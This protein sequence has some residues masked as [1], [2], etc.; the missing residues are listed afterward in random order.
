VLNP[1]KNSILS[2]ILAISFMSPAFAQTTDETSDVMEEVVVMATKREQT[3]QEVPIAVSVV[4]A[5]VLEQAHITDMIQLQSLVPSLKVTQLQTTGN[6]NFIIR[7]FGN[8][9]NNPGIE[10]SVG[11]FIDGVYRSRSASAIADLP[12]LERIEVLRGPQSTLFGKNASAGVINIVTAAPNMNELEGYGEFTYGNYN[13]VILKGALSGPISD[14]FGFSLAVNGNSRDGYFDNLETGSEINERSRWGV[15]GQL[16]WLPSDNTTLRLIADYDESDEKC[17]GVA[18]LVAGPTTGAILLVG[19]NIVPNDAFAREQYFDF[20][21]TNKIENQGVSLQ[22]DF[23][24]S[25]DMVLTSITAYREMSRLDNAD[26]DFTSAELISINS[27]DTDIETFTQEFRLSQSTDSLDWML[28]AYYFD[29]DLTHDNDIRY[30]S[31]FRPYADILSSGNVTLLEQTMIGLGLLPPSVRFFDT[32]QGAFDRAGQDD[33][34][35]SLFG[36][37]DWHVTDR[38]TLTAGANYTKVKKDAFI[39]QTNTDIFSALDMVEVGFGAGFFQ[40]TGLPPSLENIIANPGAA[41]IAN[42]LSTVPCSAETGPA[43]NPLLGLQPLQFLPPF[44]DFPNSVESGTSDDSK[45]TWTARAAFQANDNINLY[46][47]AGTGFKA[48]SWNLSRDSRPFLRD[49]PALEAAGLTVNNLTPGT[50][51]AGP[52]EALVYELGFKGSWQTTMLNM[53]LFSQE[54]DGFQS[55]IFTG[56]GFVLANAGKQSTTGLE[57]DSLWLPTESLKFNFSGTWLDPEYDSFVQGEGV[58]GPEDLSGTTPSG[59]PE[60]SM[61]LAGTYYFDFGSTSGFV[62]GEYIYE[63]DVQVVENVSKEI[64]SR[65][66]SMFNA[67]IGLAWSNGLE[68][69]LWGRNLNNDDFLLSAFPGVAQPGTFSGYPNQPRTY[70]VTFRARF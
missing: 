20:D 58:N 33:R 21:P 14:T 67:S 37:V 66:I 48:T 6:T 50:R 41:A 54:I 45:T 29:E 52:E 17:C 11:V 19:G 47:S 69:T 53:A 49:I 51:Y 36:Q 38:L 18:N 32:G 56:T 22:A 46:V 13:Q 65:E 59:I 12:Y 68:L 3:L 39:Q 42:A 2:I 35:T 10:P 43:C 61:N 16:L 40:L 63:S 55:N 1:I 26:V 24:F 34:T 9:A 27:G 70:G 7:G 30:D 57:V 4:D 28:G 8:G 5:E 64:A 62:R 25:N 60:F 23:N 15:R 31:A 44:V